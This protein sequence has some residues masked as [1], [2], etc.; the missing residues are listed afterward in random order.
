[1]IVIICALLKPYVLNVTVPVD[2]FVLSY[3]AVNMLCIYMRSQLFCLAFVN[4]FSY[5]N[6]LYYGLSHDVV[7]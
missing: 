7:T 2:L 3:V 6:K 5:N 4:I 1:M